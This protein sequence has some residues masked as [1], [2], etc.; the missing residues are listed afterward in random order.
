MLATIFLQRQNFIDA[1]YIV[2]FSL[3]IYGMSGLT[4][5]R[6]AVR[7]NKIAAV[8]MAVAV[9]ATLLTPHV[10]SGSSTPWL[11]VL[12]LGLGTA[13][14]VPAARNVHM[15]AMPQMV[16]LFNGVGGGAAALVS[17]VEFRDTGGFAHA[18]G[19]HAGEPTYVAVFSLFAAIGGPVPFRGSNI[20]FGKLQEILPG[21]PIT[22]GRPQQ[23]VNFALL[24]A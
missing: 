2:A 8:G 15:T 20:A 6:T 23:V 9:I 12:G 3:F 7:G 10:W 18:I 24:A 16:A 22:L 1:L 14:G 11:I 17:W 21:R 5:P 4:G 13:V 19:S